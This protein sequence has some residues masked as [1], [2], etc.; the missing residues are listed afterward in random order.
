VNRRGSAGA[1]GRGPGK[2][3]DRR[4]QI[5]DSGFR[6]RK[7]ICYMNLHLF[8]IRN[9][10]SFVSK[11]LARKARAARPERLATEMIPGGSPTCCGS[12]RRR[13]PGRAPRTGMP[14]GAVR[15]MTRSAHGLAIRGPE[16]AHLG[17]RKARKS[18]RRIR[19]AVQADHP[20][21]TAL[22]L[23]LDKNQRSEVIACLDAVACL[24]RLWSWKAQ[25]LRLPAAVDGLCD[26][27]RWLA[28]RG[29]GTSPFGAGEGPLV[30]AA[31]LYA[32]DAIQTR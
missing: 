11:P 15:R 27:G 10:E 6:I 23:Q 16:T 25:G 7:S 14:G 28:R 13:A 26:S 20:L 9:L 8:G 29:F 12:C 3:S 4:F 31:P 24:L 17:A 19:G 22:G 21:K 30:A 2:E 32:E 1:I 18:V 5:P